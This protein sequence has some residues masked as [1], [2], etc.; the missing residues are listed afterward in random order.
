MAMILDPLRASSALPRCAGAQI[1][2]AAAARLE[3]Y[4]KLRCI[5]SGAALASWLVMKRSTPKL[6]LR[7][8]TLRVLTAEDRGRVAGGFIMQDTIIVPT[9]RVIGVPAQDGH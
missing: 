1:L 4:A 9:S 3:R 5:S 8:Q 7:P 6:A 2:H